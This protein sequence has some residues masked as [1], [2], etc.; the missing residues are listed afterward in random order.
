M[1]CTLDHTICIKEKEIWSCI[2]TCRNQCPLQLNGCNNMP[3]AIFYMSTKLLNLV[4][5]WHHW[6]F[7]G[8]NA[9]CMNINNMGPHQ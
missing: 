8:L 5:N 6:E 3:Y 4:I 7:D 1:L 2:T 9:A